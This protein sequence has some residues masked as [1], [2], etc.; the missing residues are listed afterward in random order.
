MLKFSEKRDSKF[1]P[2]SKEAAI[3]S[4]RHVLV[5]VAWWTTCLF[6]ENAHERLAK[7]PNLHPASS[8]AK[9]LCA[10]NSAG[11]IA[12]R[13]LLIPLIGRAYDLFW[14]GVWD[15]SLEQLDVARSEL[16]PLAQLLS[17]PIALVGPYG[18]ALVDAD[19]VDLLL[20]LIDGLVARRA[21][22]HGQCVSLPHMA[23]LSGLAEK[24]IRMAAKPQRV[25]KG[26]VKHN[27]SVLYTF[28]DG[29]RTW[30]KADE[31]ARW[32]SQK[33]S[34]KPM[35]LTFGRVNL[36]PKTTLELSATLTSLR[37]SKGLTAQ[38][39]IE[40]CGLPLEA[41]AAYEELEGGWPTAA[42]INIKYFDVPALLQ[43]SA[44]L[45]VR[46]RPTFVQAVREIFT[47]LEI[48]K[49]NSKHHSE[50]YAHE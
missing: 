16:T 7:V 33:P 47:T 40:K 26:R 43:L 39:L 42:T 10:M 18:D 22:A 29:Q 11:Q 17:M 24:T 14:T 38:E 21:L 36:Q 50:R 8:D 30:V 6:D 4:V 9:D 37:E 23:L 45:N 44:V 34:Y 32:L 48:S 12:E 19:V 2:H 15:G 13:S 25:S 3:A 27:D 1:D 20:P 28:K 35:K 41:V 49:A 31:A 46:Q 5:A